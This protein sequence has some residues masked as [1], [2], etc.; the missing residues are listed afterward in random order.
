MSDTIIAAII[1]AIGAIIGSVI[2][3][4]LSKKEK[5]NKMTQKG[6]SNIFQGDNG[7]VNINNNNVHPHYR[8]EVKNNVATTSRI[9]PSTGTEHIESI[10]LD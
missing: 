1:T 4:H 10:R 3:V 9:D 7:T 5:G 6:N 8:T 2:V